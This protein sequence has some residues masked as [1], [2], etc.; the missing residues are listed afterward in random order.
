MCIRDS[1]EIVF[2]LIGELFQSTLGTVLAGG[3]RNPSPSPNG[4]ADIPSPETYYRRT[5]G[6][7]Y[8]Q[9]RFLNQEGDA[10]I[11]PA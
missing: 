9:C 11:I 3:K 6:W 8:R 7:V 2:F 4:L 10:V 1:S 5:T